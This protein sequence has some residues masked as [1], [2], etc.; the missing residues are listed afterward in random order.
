MNFYSLNKFYNLQTK[1]GFNNYISSTAVIH[2]GV[3]IGSDC[4]IMDNVV[5]FPN[6]FIGDRVTIKPNSVIGGNGMQVKQING[7]RKNIPHVGGVEIQDDVEIGSSVCIDKGLFGEFTV[8]GKETK[9][10]NLVH[11]AHSVVV[12]ENCTIAAGTAIAGVVTVGN[13]TW[14]GIN[15]SIN[16]LLNI[17]EYSLV[18]T[19]S[20]IIKSVSPHEKVFGSPARSIGWVCKCRSEIHSIDTILLCHKCRRKYFLDEN[21]VT[22]IK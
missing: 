14:L 22:E 10:D 12:G 6:T 20:V 9:I 16:Q 7:K 19:G 18:G 4:T 2:E 17:G 5:I 1:R 11:I 8:I 21:K 15:C 13:N 3:I